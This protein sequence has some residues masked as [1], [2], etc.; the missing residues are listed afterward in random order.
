MANAFDHKHYVPIMKTKAGEQ[1]ALSTLSSAAGQGIT[2]LLEV[3]QHKT[4]EHVDHVA[5]EPEGVEMCRLNQ[6]LQVHGANSSPVRS[7]SRTSARL[8]ADLMVPSGVP[9]SSPIC[10]SVCPP[11]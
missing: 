5:E 8:R 7:R 4:K 10:R 3:H 1:W 6:F 11:R 9:S 2:P